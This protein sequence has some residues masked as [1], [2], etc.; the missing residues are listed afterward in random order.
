MS[1]SK[2]ANGTTPQAKDASK[3]KPKTKKADAKDKMT[4]EERLARK[5]V[6]PFPD[7]SSVGCRS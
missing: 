3:A 2:N 7:F 4:P 6:R 1:A 5:E